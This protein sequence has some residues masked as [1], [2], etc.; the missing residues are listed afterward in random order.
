MQS[1]LFLLVEGFLLAWN[2]GGRWVLSKFLTA[3]YHADVYLTLF[4]GCFSS[5]LAQ[6]P[7]VRALTLSSFAALLRRLRY[8]EPQEERPLPSHCGGKRLRTSC[9][10]EGGLSFRFRAHRGGGWE[11]PLDANR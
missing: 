7:N 5:V 4:F 10:A 2:G 11:L 6:E 3:V 9:R 1:S 8:N